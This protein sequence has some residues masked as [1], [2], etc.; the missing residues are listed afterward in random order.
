MPREMLKRHT[1]YSGNAIWKRLS[2]GGEGKAW[3]YPAYPQRRLSEAR[4][5]ILNG[6]QFVNKA[7]R[8]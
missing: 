5:Y 6:A 8:E 1:L 7:I 3:G 2:P 4:L